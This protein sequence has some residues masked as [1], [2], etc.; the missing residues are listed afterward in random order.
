SAL[1]RDRL[2]QVGFGLVFLLT[3]WNITSWF[4]VGMPALPILNGPA[5]K[6]LIPLGDGFPTFRFTLSILTLVFGYFSKSDVLFSIW[7][8]HLLAI[9]QMGLFNRFGISKGGSD[10]WGSFD[11]TVGWQS[12]GGML[13]FVGWGLWMARVHL[14][15]VLTSALRGRSR[16]DDSGELI[17]YRWSVFLLL[18]SGVYILLFL[19]S[20]GLEWLPLLA[21]CAA[22]GI[23]YLGL[24]RIVVESGLVFMRGPISAQAFAW[25]VVGM[26][27]MSAPSAAALAFTFTIFC[28]AKTFAMTAMAHVPRL[29][30]AVTKQMRKQI[31]PA[32]LLAALVGFVTVITS[33]LYQAYYVS[34]SYN[35]GVVSFNGS[36]DGAVGIWQ[37]TA[38]RIQSGSL[39]PDLGRIGFFGIG[40]AVVGLLLYAR[41]VFPGFP[42]NPLGFT[43]AANAITQ[44]VVVSIFIVW[45]IKS[46]IMRVG[47]LDRYR[48]TAPFFLG[49][50][51]G[52]LAAATLGVVVDAIWFPGEGHALLTS[53]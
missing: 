38:S 53:F 3:F 27:H 37:L 12:L 2:F 26:T 6:H 20:T 47:G 16:V 4:F 11:P 49:M 22:T 40:A 24:A 15:E 35:F 50:L 13:V 44:N 30:E 28:D 17:S 42:L 41:Y 18:A 31:A 10:P 52:Y 21:F 48:K 29:G 33:I 25:H 51:M 1:L 7:F 5:S 46:V 39:S 34:G 43:I 36:S 32:V 19:R 45:A 14:K 9:L 8:F 23:I